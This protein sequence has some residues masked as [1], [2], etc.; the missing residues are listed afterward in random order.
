[1]ESPY[2]DQISK[3]TWSFS[4]VNSY[5]NCPFEWKLK[6]IDR[7][8][9]LNS[10]F[11][12]FGTLCHELFEAYAKDELAVYELA[13]E[14]DSRYNDVVVDEFPPS[15]GRPM[16]D[17]YYERGKELFST[18]EGFNPNWEIVGV[19]QAVDLKVDKYRFIGYIDLL[20]RDKE[21]GRLIVVDHKSKSKFANKEELK[22]Y[23][24]QLYLYSQWVFEK[25][26]EYPKQLYFNMFRAGTT[27]IIPFDEDELKEAKQWF[28]DTIHK[29]ENDVDFWDK[30][31]MSYEESGKSIEDYGFNDFYCK[32]LCGSREHCS[33]SGLK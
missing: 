31:T 14:Y 26:N 6:Y 33:M 12:E 16:A 23:A 9:Q 4:R 3:M 21:D 29:I 28:V 30:I 15:R 17:T 13:D 11:A 19:E 18:F 2:K 1:M 25:F 24:K 22:D 10:A 7:A 27:E 32:Y 20:V 8:P 5:S